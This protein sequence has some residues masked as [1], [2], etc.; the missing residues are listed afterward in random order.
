MFCNLQRFTRLFVSTVPQPTNQGK[1]LPSEAIPKLQ[2]T[3]GSNWLWI[4]PV[5]Q[6]LITNHL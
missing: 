3:T 5:N 4:Q 2:M 1:P 6:T